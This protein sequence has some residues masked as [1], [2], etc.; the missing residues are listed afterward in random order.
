MNIYK[1]VNIIT[2]TKA[3]CGKNYIITACCLNL[4]EI[5]E[6]NKL[7]CIK[8][9]VS[10]DGKDI[11]SLPGTKNEKISVWFQ[12]EEDTMEILLG[13]KKEKYN[14]MIEEGMVELDIVSFARGRNIPNAIIWINEAQNFTAHQIWTIATR[15]AKSSKLI[16]SG[17][18][19]QI[20]NKHLDSQNCGLNVFSTVSRNNPDATYICLTNNKNL[21]GPVAEWYSENSYI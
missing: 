17:D 1:P 13:G 3:G 6:Y 10:V 12:D 4:L 20:D 16:V 8:P 14:E 19:S 5:G 11:G 9:M 2:S 21:R 7:I 18:L 15:V